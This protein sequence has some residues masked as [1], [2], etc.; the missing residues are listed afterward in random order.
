MAAKD[1]WPAGALRGR[2]GREQCRCAAAPPA[3][4]PPG[5]EADE[6]ASATHVPTQPSPDGL[7]AAAGLADAPSAPDPRR[8]RRAPSR[9]RLAAGRPP[10]RAVTADPD[11]AWAGMADAPSAPGRHNQPSADRRGRAGSVSTPLVGLESKPMDALGRA[12]RIERLTIQPPEN[13]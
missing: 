5:S 3:P 11:E 12:G 10:G 2:S 6:L 9:L 8:A 4:G 1:G 7:V 13:L